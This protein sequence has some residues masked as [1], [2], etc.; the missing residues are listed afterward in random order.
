MAQNPELGNARSST[1]V[2]G[3]DLGITLPTGTEHPQLTPGF[4]HRDAGEVPGLRYEQSRKSWLCPRKNRAQ[5]NQIHW[6]KR[7]TDSK[8]IDYKLTPEVIG[9]SATSLHPNSQYLLTLCNS[10][11]SVSL[12][13][14][15]SAAKPAAS[16][17]RKNKKP[18]KTT[19]KQGSN[20]IKIN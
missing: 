11:A 8:C 9:S 17:G 18:K 2:L 20:T 3:A 13:H 15:C 4:V 14:L 10:L 6:E 16:T 1:A 19:T 5:N 12:H 7:Q